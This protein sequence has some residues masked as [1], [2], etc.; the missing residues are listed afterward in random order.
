MF[1]N[2]KGMLATLYSDKATIFRVNWPGAVNENA[3]RAR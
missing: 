3:K 1:L 2:K